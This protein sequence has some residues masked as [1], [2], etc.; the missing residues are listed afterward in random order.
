MPVPAAPTGTI[1]DTLPTFSW[2]KSTNAS[3]YDLY[4]YPLGSS[5]PVLSAPTLLSSS[6]CSNG[7]CTWTPVVG[8]DRGDYQFKVRAANLDGYSSFSDWGYF[9]IDADLTIFHIFIPYINR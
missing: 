8:L 1:T 6:I 5:T 4:V 9:T 3:W 2:S 7:T